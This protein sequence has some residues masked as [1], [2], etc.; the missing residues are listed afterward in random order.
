MHASS[1][2]S[3]PID[4][5]LPKILQAPGYALELPAGR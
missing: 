2:I 1:C 4:N 5:F 3:H